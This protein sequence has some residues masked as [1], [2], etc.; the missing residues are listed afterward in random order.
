[1]R[2]SWRIG[3]LFNIDIY[4]DSSW[5]LIFILFTWVLSTSYY[6]QRFPEW[7]TLQMWTLGTLT[8]LLLFASV[9]FHELAH[10]LVAIQQGEQVRR[11]TL[12]ILGGVAQISGEPKEPLK[13]FT[14]ALAGPF[15]SVMLSV[16]FLLLSFGL[17]TVSRP[18]SAAAFY[19]CMINIALAAFNMLPGF[20]MDGGRVLRSLI[21]KLTGD[22]QKATRI[23]SRVG[24]GFAMLFI[25]LGIFQIIQGFLQGLWL[26]FIGWFLN[27]ASTRGYT[28]VM[29]AGVLK[30]KKAADLMDPDFQTVPGRMSVQ[31]LVDD[32]MLQKRSRVFLVAE[33]ADQVG[34][35]CLED[36]KALARDSWAVTPVNSV[37]TP[38]DELVP[39]SPDT[40]GNEV[41]KTLTTRDLHQVPVMEEGRIVGIICRAE[42]IRTIRLHSELKNR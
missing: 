38:K 29:F 11:I 8:C 3:R 10:S 13:E 4:V 6:P 25:F 15:A 37:M 34:I 24:Q 39:V 14:M 18:L 41:L 16:A 36:V 7:S 17:H 1:M 2:H 30:G 33:G 20:P 26:I 32:F 40:D 23:A 22:L 19:L 12:F 28:Q 42:L 27:N 9:L 31:E 35:V 21:W 5:F